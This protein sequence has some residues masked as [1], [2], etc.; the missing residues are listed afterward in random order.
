MSDNAPIY[1]NGIFIREVSEKMFLENINLTKLGEF[2]RNNPECI[3]TS[4]TGD[5]FLNVK[6][7]KR[8][9]PGNYGDTHFAAWNEP[10]DYSNGSEPQQSQENDDLPF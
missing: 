7:I 6:V 9:E 4:K 5:K 8:K 2:V 1:I 3:S 10:K